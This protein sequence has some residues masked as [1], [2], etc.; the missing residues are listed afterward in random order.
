MGSGLQ[1]SD[2]S[3]EGVNRVVGL[4]IGFVFTIA[5]APCG[6]LYLN[7]RL[8]DYKKMKKNEK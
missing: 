7:Q 4:F 1:G 2:F 3:H 6:F 8:R 5:C